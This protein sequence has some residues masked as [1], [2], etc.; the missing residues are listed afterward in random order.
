[1]FGYYLQLAFRNLRRNAFWLPADTGRSDPAFTTVLGTD[2]AIGPAGV[3]R[4]VDQRSSGRMDL[5]V[6]SDSAGV[7]VS[8]RPDPNGTTRAIR[9]RIS[10]APSL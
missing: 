9:Q 10:P 2:V 7:T 4:G 8:S 5:H 1:M 3:A 6:W